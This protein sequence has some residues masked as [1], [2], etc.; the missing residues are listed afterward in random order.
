[1]PGPPN[2]CFADEGDEEAD[3][4]TLRSIGKFGLEPDLRYDGTRIG[5]ADGDNSDEAD[6]RVRTATHKDLS[7]LAKRLMR[8]TRS[9]SCPCFTVTTRIRDQKIRCDCAH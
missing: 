1:M 3:I 8:G 7:D 5:H 4:R 9:R 2:L 6:N